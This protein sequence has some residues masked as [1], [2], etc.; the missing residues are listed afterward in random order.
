MRAV[1]D[2][3]AH[4]NIEVAD[5]GIGGADPR[6]GS[7]LRG[8]AD[9]LAALDGTISIIS[10]IGGGT[11]ICAEIPTDPLMA[12]SVSTF[13]V[14]FRHA[15]RLAGERPRFDKREVVSGAAAR[16][17]MDAQPFAAL[18]D[19]RAERLKARDLQPQRLL[20]EY[21]KQLEIVI[22]AVDRMEK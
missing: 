15:L 6:R 1:S 9:R 2:R 16:F 10:P 22:E 18:L 20:K 4:L 21:L 13:C 12:D 19:L 8:L 7:G 11:R 17:G 14:L 3:N 5:D